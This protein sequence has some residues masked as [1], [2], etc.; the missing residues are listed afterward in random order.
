MSGISINPQNIDAKPVIDDIISKQ[1]FEIGA[2]QLTVSNHIPNQTIAFVD[3]NAFKLIIRN[4]LSNSIKFT[5]PS[6]SIEFFST[7]ENGSIIFSIKDT[8][9]GI[10]EN[11]KDSI[12]TDKSKSR[13]GTNLEIGNGFGLS[14]CKDFAVRMNGD[15]YFESKEN[16]GTTFFLELP[17]SDQIKANI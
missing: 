15:I 6:G 5:P 2:K 14:L 17:K 10:P 1:L 7:E 9:I 11:L 13:N 16:A 12:F 4:L 3:L 8:G